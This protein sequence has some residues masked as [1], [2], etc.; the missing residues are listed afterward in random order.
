MLSLTGTKGHSRSIA[1]LKTEVSRYTRRVLDVAHG[2]FTPLVFTTTGEMGKEC[3]RYHSRLAEP[4]AAKKK[5]N[6]TRKTISW[7]Q[8]RTSF[9]L[10]RSAL[11]CFRGLRAGNAVLL[12]TKAIVIL[13]PQLPKEPLTLFSVS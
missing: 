3:I 8:A 12:L 2:S 10:L 11:V 7:I 1:S 9:A 13:K 4:I 6:I 5:E